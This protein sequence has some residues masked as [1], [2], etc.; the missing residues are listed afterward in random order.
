MTTKTTAQ[1]KIPWNQRYI[2][3]LASC[4][5]KDPQGI[6]L[7]AHME[8]EP[9]FRFPR[10]C[11]CCR[12]PL[13]PRWWLVAKRESGQATRSL[14]STSTLPAESFKAEQDKRFALGVWTSTAQPHHGAH[15]SCV[16]EQ[17]SLARALA[18]PS[19]LIP[20]GDGSG[21]GGG[22]LGIQPTSIARGASNTA[23]TA[24]FAPSGPADAPATP[25]APPQPMPVSVDQIARD[26]QAQLPPFSTFR[27][28]QIPLGEVLLRWR[29]ATVEALYQCGMTTKDIIYH[30]SREQEDQPSLLAELNR[31]GL[32]YRLLLW[33]GGERSIFG[34]HVPLDPHKVPFSRADWRQLGVKQPADLGLSQAEWNALPASRHPAESWQQGAQAESSNRQREREQNPFSAVPQRSIWD[35]SPFAW[36]SQVTQTNPRQQPQPRDAGGRNPMRFGYRP[37][38]VQ[39]PTHGQVQPTAPPLGPMEPTR[40]RHYR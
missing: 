25:S 30:V 3:T 14:A 2:G 9:L 16:H 5:T 26:N 19:A 4:F 22:G 34:E 20:K 10:L 27:R 13:E 6:I 18:V 38:N 36:Q 37:M 8:Q 21:S 23:A 35:P 40:Q 11:V 12:L 31:R 1:A 17:P 24:A 7:T 39:N 29:S 28:Q 32:D 33:A 15:L